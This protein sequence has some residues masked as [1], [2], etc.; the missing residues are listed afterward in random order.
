[1][2]L[3]ILKGKNKWYWRIRAKNGRIIAHSET[4]SNKYQAQK[5]VRAVIKW[6]K[7]L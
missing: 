2:K 6:A 3:E 1:M 5:T 7:T 4:Y